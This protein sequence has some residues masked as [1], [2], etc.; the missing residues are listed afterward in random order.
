M[1][2][3]LA[4]LAILGNIHSQICSWDI[5][6]ISLIC[7]SNCCFD[8]RLSDPPLTLHKSHTQFKSYQL[9]KVKTWFSLPWSISNHIKNVHDNYWKLKYEGR[10]Q[11][12]QAK[13]N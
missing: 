2:T 12:S 7:G 5:I 13:Y 9:S 3:I 1:A 8:C 4:I 6:N 11:I 10:V